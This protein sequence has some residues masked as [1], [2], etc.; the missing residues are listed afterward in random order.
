MTIQ[1]HHCIILWI[2]AFLIGCA[3]SKQHKALDNDGPTTE[4]IYQAVMGDIADEDMQTLSGLQYSHTHAPYISIEQDYAHPRLYNPDITLH[5]Y[6][7]MA[8][9]DS[10]PIP[11]Y[12]TVFPLYDKT[13]YAMPG[14][15]VE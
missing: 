7:H 2:S 9:I 10:A 8:S 14:E 13:I 15:P 1:R 12:T 5:V 6:P 11:A 4:Q 3:S